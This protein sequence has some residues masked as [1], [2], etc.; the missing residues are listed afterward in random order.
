MTSDDDVE[1]FAR[2]YYGRFG[3]EA[4]WR[5]L[6]Q[7]AKLAADGDDEGERVWR[8]VAVAIERLNAANGRRR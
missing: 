7:S 1:L 2:G 4:R 5:A 8:R 6:D 3:V